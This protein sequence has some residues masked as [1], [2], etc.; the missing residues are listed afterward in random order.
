MSIFINDSTCISVFI[1]RSYKHIM[2]AK[3]IMDELISIRFEEFDHCMD[4]SNIIKRYSI[5][6]DATFYHNLLLFTRN[7][8]NTFYTL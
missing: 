7:Q 2:P 6:F 1:Y 4:P 5:K 8:N 3:C